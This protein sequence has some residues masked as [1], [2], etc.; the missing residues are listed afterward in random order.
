MANQ[1]ETKLTKYQQLEK[2]LGAVADS[3][4]EEVTLDGESGHRPIYVSLAQKALCQVALEQDKLAGSELM[5]GMAHSSNGKLVGPALDGLRVMSLYCHYTA[6]MAGNK[7]K[8]IQETAALMRLPASLDPLKRIANQRSKIA[9][10]TETEHGLGHISYDDSFEQVARGNYDVADNSV[11]MPELDM[12]IA[13]QK[14]NTGDMSDGVGCRAQKAGQ[15]DAIFHHVV[16]I[17]LKDK[18]LSPASYSRGRQF[19]KNN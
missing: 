15:L 7:A 3:W 19:A 5:H 14:L 8:S 11:V 4:S 12:E 2:A 10:R 13:R 18:R 6:L 16:T 9:G 17:C 1:T